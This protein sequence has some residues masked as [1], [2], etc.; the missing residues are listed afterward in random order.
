MVHKQ[1]HAFQKSR[2]EG[3][4]IVSDMEKKLAKGWDTEISLWFSRMNQV[5]FL[6]GG[7]RCP[8]QELVHGLHYRG[9]VFKGTSLCVRL[10]FFGFQQL[11][12]ATPTDK[13]NREKQFDPTSRWNLR[14]VNFFQQP[15]KRFLANTCFKL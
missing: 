12:E 3:E 9:A 1:T 11:W 13:P 5:M 10:P 6:F 7:L 4:P 14:L 15:L 8:T 2:F